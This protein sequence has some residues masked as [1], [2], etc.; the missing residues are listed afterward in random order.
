MPLKRHSTAYKCIES[1]FKIDQTSEKMK[2]SA[3]V[4][5]SRNENNETPVCG[6][7]LGS[8]YV[9][10]EN[11]K[12]QGSRGSRF[13]VKRLLARVKIALIISL[14]NFIFCSSDI[15]F[16]VYLVCFFLW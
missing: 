11:E 3:S 14:S 7:R 10:R 1:N 6:S 4:Y 5:L 16:K 8:I 12:T 2:I 13:R 15:F 9:S